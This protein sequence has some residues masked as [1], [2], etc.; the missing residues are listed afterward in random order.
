MLVELRV[1]EQRY[2]AVLEV[3]DGAT[4]I[5][6]A[7]RYGV[8]RQTVHRW[9]RQVRGRRGG[10]AGGWVAGAGV[11]SASDAAEVEARIVEMRREHPGWGP[12]TIGHQLG[13][14]GFEPVPAKSSIYRCLVRHGLITPVA[15]GG[16]GPTIGV[17]NGRGRWSCGRWTSSAG[18][19][20][21]MGPERRS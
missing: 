9:L 14:E 1:V 11:V 21:P 4:V 7:A 3:L 10:G 2:Q 20:S 18:S 13:R 12:R 8:T 5:G 15:G 6:V 17:G 19:G 16:S